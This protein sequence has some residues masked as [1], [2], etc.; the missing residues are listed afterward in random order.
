MGY[1]ARV[2]YAIAIYAIAVPAGGQIPQEAHRHKR[3]YTRIVQSEWGL[4]APVATL[5]GQ[6]AQES[7][8]QCSA[9]S[10]AGARGCAQFLPSTAAWIGEVDD[11]LKGGDLHSF[12]WSARA[13]VVYMKWLRERIKADNECERM[14]FAL[15][16][17]NSGLGWVY[18][19]QK[20]SKTPGRC[21]DAS[22]NINP[23][24]L[25]A[26]QLEAQEYPVRIEKR[27]AP[28]F[29]AALW[30]ERSCK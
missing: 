29:V 18:K 8:F 7:M 4:S 15:Q 19:R 16:S 24:V 10:R 13:Q 25:V 26:N 17:Y 5:A 9:V 14:A 6:I 12:A 11:R 3:E 2:V 22:C 21:F 1:G 27:W 30:G 28:R 20:L 23:G